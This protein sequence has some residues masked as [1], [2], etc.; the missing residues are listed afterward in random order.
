MP[1]KSSRMLL[2]DQGLYRIKRF[3]KATLSVLE[4][5]SF[6]PKNQVPTLKVSQIQK[7]FFF[8]IIIEIY[9]TPI[10]SAKI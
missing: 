7:V 9:I 6:R 10:L 8:F 2:D 1:F 5:A 3:L 4:S